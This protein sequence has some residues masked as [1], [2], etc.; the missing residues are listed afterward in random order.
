MQNYLGEIRLFG[1]NFA[2][3]GWAFCAGQVLAIST[4]TTLFAL[5]GTTY[6]G[7]GVSSFQL[8]DLRGRIPVGEGQGV[9]LSNYAIGQT[10]G[11]ENVT[12]TQQQL[13]AHNHVPNATTADGSVPTPGPT[14]VLA[15]PV[16][17][18][19]RLY[20]TPVAGKTP[21]TPVALSNLAIAADGGGGAHS[22]LMPTVCLN[23][24]IALEGIFPSRN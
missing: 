11:V 1:G 2:P 5:I 9:G 4:N 24:I 19:A 3:R 10:G 21:P 15:K 7:D 18:N 12:L 20:V 6:G 13:P 17:A 22:N 23:Y 16:A 8:P 14:V